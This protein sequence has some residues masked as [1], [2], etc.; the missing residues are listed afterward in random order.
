METDILPQA[1]GPDLCVFTDIPMLR[2]QRNKAPLRI[3]PDQTFKYRKANIQ[4]APGF[5]P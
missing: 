4:Q 1:E 2:E 3:V 5:K